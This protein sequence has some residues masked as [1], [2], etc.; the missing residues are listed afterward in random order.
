MEWEWQEGK[1][2][3]VMYWEK[4]WACHPSI[5]RHSQPYLFT[6]HPV[7]LLIRVTIGAG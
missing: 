5:P 1:A 4:K 7:F 2:G 6:P 3:E